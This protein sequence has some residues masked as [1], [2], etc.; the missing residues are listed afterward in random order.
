MSVEHH[1]LIA[2]FPQHRERLHALK[3]DARFTRLG[4]AYE[5][6]DKQ[7]VRLEGG[8]EHCGDAQL[9]AL[10]KQRVALKDELYRLL[11]SA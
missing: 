11:T 4:Q 2:E 8:I 6:L 9:E 7:I 3:A 1:P 5:A 10:K